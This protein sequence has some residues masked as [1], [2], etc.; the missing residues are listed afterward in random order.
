VNVKFLA[1]TVRLSRIIHYIIIVSAK[2]KYK[3][4]FK[5]GIKENKSSERKSIR[6]M[7]F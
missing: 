4:F 2:K 6:N 1:Y 5:N 7:T 3:T